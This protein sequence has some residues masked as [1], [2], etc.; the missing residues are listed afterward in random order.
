[1]TAA[2]S[3]TSLRDAMYA[4]SLAKR[5]PDAELLEQFVRRYPKHA[6]ALTNFAIEL[7][8]DA[9]EH[10]DEEVG[11]PENS[12]AIS[13]VVSRVM[14]KFQ[15]GLFGIAQKRVAER[16][17]QIAHTHSPPTN[18]FASLNRDSYRALASRLDINTVMLSK[19]RD[20]QIKPTTIPRG[21]CR[22]VAAGMEEDV[23]VLCAHFRAP[24]EA[25][26]ARQYFKAKDKPE[27]SL[28]QSFEQAVRASGLT[29][30]QQQRLL[31]F[32][33]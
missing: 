27:M 2:T 14:S 8:L 18:P 17:V 25:A 20:R 28:Q 21:F 3:N 13:P 31:A 22:Y 1:M 29:E 24:P 30:E 7:T 4:M 15:N 5:A 12:E 6:E 9:L 19:L 26:P 33:E 16:P 23:E 11:A 32:C 10:G